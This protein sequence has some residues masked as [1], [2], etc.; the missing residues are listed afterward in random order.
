MRA[1]KVILFIV[2]L[3]TPYCFAKESRDGSSFDRAIIIRA[4]LDDEMKLERYWMRKLYGIT[5]LIPGEQ[6]L[7][8]HKGT[9]YDLWLLNSPS[10]KK[11]IYFDLGPSENCKKKLKSGD[12]QKAK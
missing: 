2:L 3:T 11:A 8:C 6:G 5:S 9:M 10:G 12:H 7:V 4:S 1:W